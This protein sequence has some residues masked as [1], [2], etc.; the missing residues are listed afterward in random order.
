MKTQRKVCGFDETDVK[1]YPSRSGQRNH[2][3]KTLPNGKEWTLVAD[4][5]LTQSQE[6]ISMC[7]CNEPLPL[8]NECTL[9]EVVLYRILCHNLERFATLS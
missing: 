8:P 9:A 6:A 1:M 4:L 2:C 3:N 7:Y 5:S